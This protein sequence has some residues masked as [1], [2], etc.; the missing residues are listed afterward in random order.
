MQ[1]IGGLRIVLPT[2]EDVY[3]L[4]NAI[5]NDIHEPILPP[6]DYTET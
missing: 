5:I 4:H 3:K 6:F 1:D 2:I